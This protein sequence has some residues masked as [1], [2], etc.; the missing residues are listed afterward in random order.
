MQASNKSRDGISG[1][2]HPSDS[3][4]LYFGVFGGLGAFNSM[5]SNE[6]VIRLIL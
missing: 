3:I 6:I 2:Y 4:S 1:A 5:L